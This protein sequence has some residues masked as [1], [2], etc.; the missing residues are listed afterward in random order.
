MINIAVVC[1]AHHD[2]RNPM[3]RTN[4]ATDSCGKWLE[5]NKGDEK[6]RYCKIEIVGS[7]PY[8]RCEACKWK[9]GCQGVV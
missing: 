2:D 1:G 8:V 6:K 3:I 9:S 4:A 7:R 5:K